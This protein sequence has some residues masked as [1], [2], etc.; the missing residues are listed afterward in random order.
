MIKP[1]ATKAQK[2]IHE[3]VALHQRGQWEAA[4][5]IYE[6]VLERY[7]DNFD[8]LHL[9]GVLARDTGRHDMAIALIQQA[10]QTH[11]QSSA[12]HS[13]LG[14]ALAE[15]GQQ[16]AALASFDRA[17]VLDPKNAQ[18]QGNRGKLLQELKRLDEALAS[19]ERALAL[20]PHAAE[21]HNIHGSILLE[22]K[23]FEDALASFDTAI[24]IEPRHAHAYNGRGLALQKLKRNKDAL[25]SY[26]VATALAPNLPGLSHRRGDVLLE[27][28]QLDEA[29][30]NY[31][32]ALLLDPDASGLFGAY[33]RTKV[34]LCDWQDLPAKI[35]QYET[36]IASGKPVSTPFVVFGLTDQPRLHQIMASTYSA[37]ISQSSPQPCPQPAPHPKIRIGYYSSD[38]RNH[39]VAFHIAEFFELH[40][41]SR[42]ELY[43]FAFGPDSQDAIRQRI[44]AACTEFIDVDAMS[45]D[46]VVQLS[47]DVGIDI[48]VDLNGYTKNHR[49]GIFERRC[50]PIQLQYMGYPG[51]M[52]ADYMDY[53]VAD[54]TVVPAENQQYFTEKILY[55][56]H[57]YQVNDRQ[58]KISDRVFS[59]EELGLPPQGF[60]F[61]CF[62]NNYKIL[63]ATFDGWMRILQAVPGSVLWLFEDNPTAAKNLR[64]HAQERGVAPERL[65]FAK[66]IP[67][68]EHL[69]RQHMA[70]LFLDTL[71]YNGHATASNAL[72]TGL[73]LLTCMGQSFASRVA[74][75]LLKAID[76]PELITT[77]QAEY[78][79]RAIELAQDPAQLQAIKQKMEQNRLTTPLFNT[80]LFTKHMQVAYEAMHERYQAG[81]E[82]DHI[83]IAP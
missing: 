17:L 62:N 65:V 5:A 21:F 82:P 30:A 75:S 81:L 15:S 40:D 27:L 33:V 47:R 70:D 14:L 39:A 54:H 29:L 4:R 38:F 7:P 78:E 74:A 46:D 51:T 66:L 67:L 43:G 59:K 19:C 61:C 36:D 63:P 1:I 77:T 68:E 83:E 8:C 20:A 45:D 79:A 26:D 13:N 42:F 35:S 3:A 57:C 18:A 25:I 73:P 52:G 50:A 28:R 72:W 24:Q 58:R 80:P 2:R 60:V 37:S 10:L 22:L 41:R 55:L 11:P 32:Q 34:M 9:L 69:A 6:E 44:S 71:P 56:P 48:A 12:A 23:R 49:I 31:E 16:D 53:A 64:Q 76:V